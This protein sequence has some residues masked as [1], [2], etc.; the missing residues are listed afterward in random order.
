MNFSQIL[1]NG[2]WEEKKKVL[3]DEHFFIQNVAEAKNPDEL[4]SPLWQS[5]QAETERLE[6]CLANSIQGG[7]LY[8]EHLNFLLSLCLLLKR[9]D[10]Q[11]SFPEECAKFLLKT[12]SMLRAS[13]RPKSKEFLAKTLSFLQKI[14]YTSPEMQSFLL[15]LLSDQPQGDNPGYF[16]LFT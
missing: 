5:F 10:S 2:T 11:Y 6:Y 9:R 13:P 12:I 14:K 7:S 15:S 4:F 3:S 1:K 16:A 8:T